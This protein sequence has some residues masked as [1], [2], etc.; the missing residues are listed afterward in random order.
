MTKFSPA[1]S[2]QIHI[3]TLKQIKIK[4]SLVA[5]RQ[6]EMLQWPF[7]HQFYSCLVIAKKSSGNPNNEADYL[8]SGLSGQF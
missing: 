5:Q 8:K 2:H 1:L 7:I 4:L 6:S 3:N